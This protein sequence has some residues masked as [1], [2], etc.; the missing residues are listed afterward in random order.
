MA[1]DTGLQP[2]LAQIE[3]FAGALKVIFRQI[4]H[5]VGMPQIA[6]GLCH[7]GRQ[8]Q[9]RSMAVDFGS[10]GFAQSR[11]PGSPLAAPQ[12]EGVIEGQTDVTHRVITTA[13]AG[14]ILGAR[15]ARARHIGLGVQRRH[16]C[17]I[18][19]AGGGSG[20]MHTGTGYLHVRAVTQCLV[21]QAIQLA[22][23]QALPPVLLRPGCRGH[24]DALEGLSGLEAFRIQARALGGQAAVA[25]T[26]CQREGHT[27]Q[28]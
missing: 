18:G 22:V 7:I 12:V 16:A 9:A 8:G 4:Q 2:L 11:F 23:A 10:A 24:I 14:W 15:Q 28:A 27:H 20:L 5:A 17:R 3:H 13:L 1:V 6:V 19:S 26:T 25:G 21:D